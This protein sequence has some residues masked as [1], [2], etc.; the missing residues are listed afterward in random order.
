MFDEILGKYTGSDY[1]VELKMDA[2]P[3]HLFQYQQIT[4]HLSR[5]KLV[6]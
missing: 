6:D 2:K 1:T 3:Y 5:K 4:N